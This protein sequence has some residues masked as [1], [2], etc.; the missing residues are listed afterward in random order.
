[1]LWILYSR[2]A[3]SNS[4]LSSIRM[5]PN[6]RVTLVPSSPGFPSARSLGSR[7]SSR[8]NLAITE[9]FTGFE[10]PFSYDPARVPI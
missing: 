5:G 10:S 9:R 7:Q 1:M 6:N 2:E 4:S 3:L 8:W